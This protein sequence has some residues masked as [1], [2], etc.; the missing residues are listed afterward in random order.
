MSF[1]THEQGHAHG[2]VD[3]SIVRSRAGVQAVAVSLLVLGL[4][5]GAQAAVFALSNSVALLADLIHNAGDALTVVRHLRDRAGDVRTMTVV[6]V[7]VRR[8]ADEV[9]RHF[10]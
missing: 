4:A 9:V 3:R 2:L 5:A 1:V 7:R 10:I 8:V 6:V